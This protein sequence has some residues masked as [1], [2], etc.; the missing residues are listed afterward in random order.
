MR[1]GGGVG[2]GG[3]TVE[4][5]RVAAGEFAADDVGVFSQGDDVVGV[6]V[7]TRDSGGVVVDEDGDWGGGGDVVVEVEEGVRGEERFVVGGGQDEGVV[8]AGEEGFVA[9]GDGFAGGLGAAADDEGEGVVA[10]FVEGFPRR[11]GDE[12]ALVV[13]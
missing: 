2:G 1:R 5:A 12:F 6:K 13:S 8:T 9:E 3:D 10:G 4:F 11:F 7:N